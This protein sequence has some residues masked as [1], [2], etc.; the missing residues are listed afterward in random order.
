MNHQTANAILGKKGFKLREGYQEEGVD[1]MLSK[2]WSMNTAEIPL[3]SEPFGGILADEM[4]LGKTIQTIAVMETNLFSNTLLVVPA[5]LIEQWVAEIRKFSSNLEAIVC[6]HGNYLELANAY[7][8]PGTVYI[9]SYQTFVAHHVLFSSVRWFRVIL[10]EAHYIRN[11]KTKV[12]EK[13][14]SLKAYNKWVLSGTPIQNSIRDLHTLLMF[15]GIPATN[16]S[17]TDSQKAT[18]KEIMLLRTKEQVGINIPDKTEIIHK[19]IPTEFEREV[20]SYVMNCLD[21]E[22]P[23]GGIVAMDYQC[24]LERILRL[25]QVSIGILIFLESYLKTHK[26]EMPRVKNTR[27]SEIVRLAEDL[28]N[29]IVFCDFHAEIRYLQERLEKAGK[30]I[31]VIHGRISFQERKRILESQDNYDILIVQIYAGG[32]GLNLQRFSNVIIN[33]PH[34]NP[35]IEEQAIGRAHRDGQKN[36][37]TVHRFIDEGSI[38][39]RIRQIGESKLEMYEMYIKK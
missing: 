24:E 34:Y 27:L 12:S 32:T 25:R 30:R 38:D 8:K 10:D 14:I 39:A 16:Y 19:I 36:P 7:S 26:I 9:T 22:T 4:G 28:D 17:S 23:D 31:G 6:I 21:F 20:Q 29:C 11:L 15:I 2:E 3:I 35:F 13:I 5:S 33:I 18:L 37:V 1:W